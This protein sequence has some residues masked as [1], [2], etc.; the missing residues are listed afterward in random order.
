MNQEPE[1]EPMGLR[2]ISVRYLLKSN[3]ENSKP[4]AN[5]RGSHFFEIWNRPLP[6]AAGRVALGWN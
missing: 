5:A 2:Q 1:C 6:E 4:R 3:A